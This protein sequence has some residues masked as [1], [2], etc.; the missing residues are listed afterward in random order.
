MD[1]SSLIVA[2]NRC[3]LVATRMLRVVKRIVLCMVRSSENEADSIISVL[4]SLGVS[5]SII[6]GTGARTDSGKDTD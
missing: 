6:S 1:A 3:S 5:V 2:D 4:V